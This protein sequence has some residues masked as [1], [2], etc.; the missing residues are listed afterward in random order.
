MTTFPWAGFIADFPD[1]QVDEENDVKIFG[2]QNVALALVEILTNLGCN[3]ISEPVHA[4]EHGWEFVFYYKAEHR[5][6]CRVTSFHPAFHLIF[7]DPGAFRSTRKKNAAAYVEIWRKLA[8]ALEQ[9]PRFHH[10]VW[11]TFKEGPP[12]PDE[13]GTVAGTA[14]RPFAEEFPP[15]KVNGREG[16]PGFWPIIIGVWFIVSCIVGTLIGID[17]RAHGQSAE[18]LG[19]S[20]FVGIVGIAILVWA[21]NRRSDR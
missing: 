1:D 5:F 21:F 20:P 19:L 2:G 12:E 3:R 9:D 17:N 18:E 7:E 15:G 14:Q 8:I 16:R 11:R 13:I 4:H 10:I 6:W